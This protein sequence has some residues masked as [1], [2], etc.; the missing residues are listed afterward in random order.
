MKVFEPSEIRTISLLV[1]DGEEG[2]APL[3]EFLERYSHSTGKVELAI[4]RYW[5]T[6]ILPFLKEMLKV[7]DGLKFSKVVEDD[8][9]LSITHVYSSKDKDKMDEIKLRAA[10]AIDKLIMEK[11][12][13]YE[14]DNKYNRNGIYGY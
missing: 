8:G 7:D 13:E 5:S 1:E 14:E 4:P 6:T 9:I 10:L 12:T 11:I 3:I 2:W